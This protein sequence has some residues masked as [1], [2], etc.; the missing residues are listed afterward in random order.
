MTQPAPNIEVKVGC[1]GGGDLPVG[2]V[3]GIISGNYRLIR[4]RVVKFFCL[5][6]SVCMSGLFEGVKIS[7]KLSIQFNPFRATRRL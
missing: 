7:A 1:G 3:K 6:L 2:R 5:F 4:G